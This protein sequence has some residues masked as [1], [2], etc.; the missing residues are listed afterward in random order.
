MRFNFAPNE[1][2]QLVVGLQAITYSDSKG[3]K[4]LLSEGVLSLLDSTVPYLW[5]PRSSCEAFEEAFGITWDPVKNLYLV[6]E[7][8]HD[9]LVKNNPT[10]TFSLANSGSGGSPVKIAF[11][12]AAF[13]LNVS[14]PLVKNESRY[15]PL[16][17]AADDNSYTLGRTFFQEAY[18]ITNFENS[19]FSISQATFD[20]NNP[21]HVVPIAPSITGTSPSS[22]SASN[23]SKSTGKG[24]KGIGT[25]AIA[26]VAIA[27][28]LVGIIVAVVAFVIIRKRHRARKQHQNAAQTVTTYDSAKID[29]D[30]QRD[31]SEE[32][33][34]QKKGPIV[35]TGPTSAPM[36]PP[37]EVDGSYPIPSNSH[38]GAQELPASYEPGP[39]RSELSTPPP[40]ELPDMRDLHS[41]L[42]TPEPLY[43]DKELP[44][45]IPSHELESPRL[46]PT[47]SP[48]QPSSRI[49]S[50][51]SSTGQRPESMRIDSS[52]SESGF[53]HDG[54][55]QYHCR[56]NSDE[57][58]TRPSPARKGSDNSIESPVL[59]HI[60]A[61]SSDVETPD[62]VGPKGASRPPFRRS[63]GGRPKSQRVGSADSDTIKTRMESMAGE[64]TSAR[65]PGSRFGS[66]IG[67]KSSGKGKGVVRKPVGGKQGGNDTQ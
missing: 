9:K 33:S 25:G 52:E 1:V 36:T 58:H 34:S 2:R 67:R 30:L 42:S 57:T 5:L 61:N 7:T 20:A 39:T 18:M 59:G 47:F 50:P 63:F 38:F 22:P 45:P 64:G 51:L 49:P 35:T 26:G 43:P 41:E 54:M 56:F 4:E 16:Q 40:H 24:S 62:S 32:Q 19:T 66:L 60:S 6:N 12:Y 23:L 48:S 3:K 10:V 53:T 13:D 8:T 14:Y 11:P 15:F 29:D 46:N 55:Q 27:I 28:A 44:T 31:S 65:E 17:R 37:L 21:S